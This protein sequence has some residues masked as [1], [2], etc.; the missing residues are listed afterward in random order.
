[1]TPRPSGKTRA[2]ARHKSVI[3]WQK[4]QRFA[5]AAGDA[6]KALKHVERTFQAV[7]SVAEAQGWPRYPGTS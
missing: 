7:A 6:D 2:E 5:H 3:Y 4:A 1:M